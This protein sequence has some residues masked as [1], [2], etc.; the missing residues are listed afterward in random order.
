MLRRDDALWEWSVFWQSDQLQSCMP[1]NNPDDPEQ[2][3]S[4]W[5]EFF[6]ALPAGASILDLGTG[7]GSVATQAV[8]VSQEKSR[9]FS[10]HGVDLA[11]IDPSRFVT[12]AADL[13]QEITFHPRT[14]M[15]NL[16][17]GDNHFDAVASQYALEYS[18]TNSSLAEAI[19]VLHAPGRFRFLLHADDGVLK[20]RCELQRRQAETILGSPLFACL[21][22]AL[23]TIVAVEHR[24]TPQ[25]LA[26]AEESIEALKSVF[27]DLECEFSDSENRSL[28]DNLFAAVRRL[29]GLRKSYDLKTLLVM[30][31]DIRELLTAQAKR[32]QAM[33]QAALDE[34]EAMELVERLHNIGVADVKL[35]RATVSD[36]KI[37]IGYWLY[38]EKAADETQDC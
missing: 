21:R 11:A 20:G 23:E 4:T 6:G 29:P 2:L 28:V 18:Q 24:Q 37:C 31:D 15:E 38:G 16:P 14:P 3:F 12:S 34:D 1:T 33:E 36:G 32:L 25:T 7:N 17:F 35:E 8:A 9:R 26:N 30:A 22:S 10:I 13:L 5:R 19:R 27:D